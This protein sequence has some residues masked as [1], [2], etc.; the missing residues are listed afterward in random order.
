M[1]NIG[2]YTD[3]NIRWAG[4]PKY[5]NNLVQ[6]DLIE[7]IVQKLEMVLLTNQFE[8]LGQDGFFI[9]ADLEYYLWQTDLSNLNIESKIKNQITS[10]IPELNSIGY[11]LVLKI[12]EGTY[13]DMM[14]LNF[15]IQGFN[16]NFVFG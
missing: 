2:D 12:F 9:G 10:N 3:L 11:D 16:V 15:S 4:H 5:N 7:V 6:T 8:I 14:H 1:A 13:Q